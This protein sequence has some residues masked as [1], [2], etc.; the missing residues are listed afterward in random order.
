MT[1][2]NRNLFVKS[3]LMLVL[4]VLLSSCNTRAEQNFTLQGGETVA[5]NLF[6]FSQNAI[7]EE[8]STVEGTVFMLCCNLK[9]EGEVQGN[10]V[11]LTG[12]L[13][14]NTDAHVNGS[15]KVFSGNLTR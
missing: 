6:I 7:L 15:T 4:L 10:V 9:V 8:S 12:N 14:I 5:G 1:T 3:A 2:V 13:W 11:L